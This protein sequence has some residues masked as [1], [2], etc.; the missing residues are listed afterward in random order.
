MK[1]NLLLMQRQ[2]KEIFGLERIIDVNVSIE[3]NKK[4]INART[5]EIRRLRIACRK[6]GSKIDS[7]H[8]NLKSAS[9]RTNS[10]SARSARSIS[11]R[12]QIS[13]NVQESKKNANLKQPRYSPSSEYFT[14]SSFHL[15]SPSTGFVMNPGEQTESIF[16]KQRKSQYL[17]EKK[18]KSQNS[19]Q[20]SPQSP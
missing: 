8:V 3:K 16:Q 15:Q 14:G 20:K 1:A 5:A 12:R 13:K 6:T 18:Q 19:V 9:S 4:I 10:L 17:V 11:S 7:F 2:S